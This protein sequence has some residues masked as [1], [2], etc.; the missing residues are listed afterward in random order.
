MTITGVDYIAVVIAAA[1]AFLWTLSYYISLFKYWREAAGWSA[2]E[3]QART[4]RATYLVTFVGLMIMAWVIAGP[5]GQIGGSPM[6][7]KSGAIYAVFI[8][9]G[10]VVPIIAINNVIGGRKYILSVIDGIQWLGALVIE[11]TFIGVMRA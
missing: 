2:D 10:F 3:V 11:G 6:T 1:A 4:S 8:W 9:L 7:A 5:L